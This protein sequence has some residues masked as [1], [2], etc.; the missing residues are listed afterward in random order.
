MDSNLDLKVINIM[1]GKV[2]EDKLQELIDNINNN[3][4]LFVYSK[5]DDMLKKGEIDLTI[6]ERIIL[7]QFWIENY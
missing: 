7:D 5:I 2:S 4:R 1:K 6:E 3:H